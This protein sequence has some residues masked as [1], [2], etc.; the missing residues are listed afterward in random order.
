M[1]GWDQFRRAVFADPAL[2]RSLLWVRSEH[3][4]EAVVRAGRD[5]GME[6]APTE[7]TAAVEDGR[8]EWR[9]RW[10]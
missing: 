4:V 5:L 8:R 6:I 9:K 7:V 2:A 3:F 10:I 1:T